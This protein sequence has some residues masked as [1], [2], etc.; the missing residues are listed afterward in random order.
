MVLSK[1]LFLFT[2]WKRG[3]IPNMKWRALL[4][5]ALLSGCTFVIRTP[6]FR[7]PRDAK[8]NLFRGAF[9][10]HTEYSHDSKASLELVIKT[11]RKAGL[12][13]VVVTDHNNLNAASAYQT[14]KEPDRPLPI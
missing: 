6:A 9:H 8:P 2:L 10:V 11:A 14:M 13:F 12:D 7:P 1:V 3:I 5:L 4:F